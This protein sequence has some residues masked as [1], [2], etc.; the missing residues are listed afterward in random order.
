MQNLGGNEF[1]NDSKGILALWGYPD[2]VVLKE[3]REKYP[4]CE[5]LDLDVPIEAP[6]THILPENYCQII[7]NIVDNAVFLKDRI[8][9]IVAAVG[10]EKCDQGRFAAKIL[11][12][13]G[14]NVV[15]T[16]YNNNPEPPSS[17]E[18]STST[19]PLITKIPLIMDAL[20]DPAVKKAH[21]I[22]SCQAR[23][24]FWG[25][26]PHDLR[27][28]ELFPDETHVYGWTRCVEMNHPANL[29]IEMFVDEDVPTVFFAQTFCA[30]M[31]LA[32]YLA[33]KHDGLYVDVDD[34]MSASVRAKIEAFIR[35][36]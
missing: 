15:E 3:I 31:Q 13:M 29:D 17:P 33:R 23:Y 2:P 32:K 35:L 22:T 18:I 7:T 9:V 24:G 25:V 34:Q 30:K 5:L 6:E 20:V 28:L 26:P 16:R 11:S 27:I 10:E 14:L 12:E 21:E 36:S 19:L 1:S 4:E 8:E